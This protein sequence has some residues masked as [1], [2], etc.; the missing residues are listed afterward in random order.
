[1]FF[2]LD[3]TAE[4]KACCHWMVMYN[5]SAE[6]TVH[7]LSS[8]FNNYN[9]LSLLLKILRILNGVFNLMEIST[10]SIA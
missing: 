9:I 7:Y 5:M 2:I 10:P 8:E 4:K 3:V 6:I 1:M